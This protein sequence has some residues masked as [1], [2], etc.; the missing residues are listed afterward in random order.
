MSQKHIIL[1]VSLLIILSGVGYIFLGA[2]PVEESATPTPTTAA[3]T[4]TKAPTQQEGATNITSPSPDVAADIDL[5]KAFEDTLN[6][7]ILNTKARTTTYTKQR[8]LLF[9]AM[10]PQTLANV[11]DLNAHFMAVQR[12]SAEQRA[13]IDDI[14]LNFENANQAIENILYTYTEDKE[15]RERL[16]Q[17]WQ[18]MKTQ[19]IDAY[20]NFFDTEEQIITAQI[21]LMQLYAAENSLTY[22]S[23]QNKILVSKPQAQEQT[24]ALTALIKEFQ[25]EQANASIPSAA[26]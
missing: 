25:N 11:K 26:Q 23:A 6:T 9:K 5:S 15:E 16:S 14:L 17:I 13:T 21:N 12:L 7:L 4:E 3:P 10:S 18:T 24:D 19:Q 8:A 1:G 2:L 20:F 22:D